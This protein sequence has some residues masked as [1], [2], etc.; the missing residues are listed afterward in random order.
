MRQIPITALCAMANSGL[1]CVGTA[2]CC[3]SL[4]EL[5]TQVQLTLGLISSIISLIALLK[6]E[7]CGRFTKLTHVPTCIEYFYFSETASDVNANNTGT[8]AAAIDFPSTTKNAE[9]N[10]VGAV[11]RAPDKYLAIGTQRIYKMLIL[12]RRNIFDSN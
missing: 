11:F 2:D 7:L 10:I 8:N 12:C 4:Y 9:S 5:G 3:I 1:L 6:K